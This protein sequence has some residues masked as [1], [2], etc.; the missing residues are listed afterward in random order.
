[1]TNQETDCFLISTLQ[2]ILT[3]MQECAAYISNQNSAEYKKIRY[4]LKSAIQNLQ[5]ILHK[6]HNLEDLAKCKEKQIS[7][8]YEYIEEYYANFIIS[9]AP[10]Q[11]KKDLKDAAKIEELLSL[12]YDSDD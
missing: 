10:N 9:A 4:D 2:N 6:V 5:K 8:V 7:D 3:D 1:M 11:Q 12:F